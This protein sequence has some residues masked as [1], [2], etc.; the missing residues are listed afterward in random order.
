MI[1]VSKFIPMQL[2]IKCF[3]MK[4]STL[5]TSNQLGV[6]DMVHKKAQN[7][8]N[9]IQHELQGVQNDQGNT[10]HGHENDLNTNENTTLDE[11]F[12]IIRLKYVIQLII[13]SGQKAI[14]HS[15]ATIQRCAKAG[16]SEPQFSV[17]RGLYH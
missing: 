9:N 17:K 8:I 2:A 6:C 13:R 12:M 5:K 4:N 10:E 16:K 7:F 14:S 1:R 11:V 15:S 3:H